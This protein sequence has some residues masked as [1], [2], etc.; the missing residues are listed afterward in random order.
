M[1]TLVFTIFV[2]M[3]SQMNT[4]SIQLESPSAC[5]NAKLEL[6][7]AYGDYKLS[8]DQTKLISAFCVSGKYGSIN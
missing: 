4:T 8:T 6:V 2:G 1:T 3:Y 5:D 7:Q